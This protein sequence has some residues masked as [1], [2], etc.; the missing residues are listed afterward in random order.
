MISFDVPDIFVV[1]TYAVLSIIFFT[2]GIF[3]G[4]YECTPGTLG[5]FILGSA[6]SCRLYFELKRYLADK[7]KDKSII[8]TA[9][10]NSLRYLL[11]YSMVSAALTDGSI[12]AK[13][14]KTI[15]NIIIRELSHD[16][17]EDKILSIANNIGCSYRAILDELKL[18]EAKLYQEGKEMILLSCIKVIKSDHKITNNERA[19][20]S[21]VI[22][23]LGLPMDLHEYCS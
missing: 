13:N 9:K 6:S 20:L 4:G 7:K 2:C 21:D 14:V 3:Y 8:N 23:S 1:I 19:F 17:S 5:F 12:S 15:R 11:L 18:Y 16:I 22:A 10:D